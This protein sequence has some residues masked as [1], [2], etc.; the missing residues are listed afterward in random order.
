MTNQLWLQD[1]DDVKCPNC[2]DACY[3]KYQGQS[4]GYRP[5]EYYVEQR[6]VCACCGWICIERTPPDPEVA[7]PKQPSLS[8][9]VTS[10]IDRPYFVFSYLPIG[11]ALEHHFQKTVLDKDILRSGYAS[12]LR[13]FQYESRCFYSEQHVD[14]LELVFNDF[15]RQYDLGE[16][17][18]EAFYDID[19]RGLRNA[20]KKQEEQAG[21][22]DHAKARTLAL[23][24]L[25]TY[26]SRL[27]REK[28]IP[29]DLPGVS[30]FST[31]QEFIDCLNGFDRVWFDMIVVVNSPEEQEQLRSLPYYA[32]LKTQHWRRIRAALLLLN[33]EHRC[34][35]CWVKPAGLPNG[36]RDLHVH[37]KSYKNRGNERFDDLALLC[38]NCHAAI[39]LA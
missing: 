14:H 22:E 15:S 39:H 21:L 16:F 30:S 31:H 11:L 17:S 25:Q 2:R 26:I 20:W 18:Q 29:P 10:G 6:W 33:Y 37:H 9:G 1:R 38:T 13:Q 24:Q 8:L 34:E 7:L 23:E 4:L 5:G 19:S 32:Y 36:Q 3:L 27:E 28:A 35:R 12:W